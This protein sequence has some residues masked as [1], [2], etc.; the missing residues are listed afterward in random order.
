M[1]TPWLPSDAL[2]TAKAAGFF[3]APVPG[4]PGLR[5]VSLNTM[6]ML[7]GNPS[8]SNRTDDIAGQCAWFESVLATARSAGEHVLV[9]G[10]VPPTIEIAI[11]QWTPSQY[12]RFL[13][14]FEKYSDVIVG[15]LYGHEHTDSFS[16]VQ[17][18]A[19][20]RRSIGVAHVVPSLTPRSSTC[21]PESGDTDGK[22]PALRKYTVSAKGIVGYVQYFA[23][24]TEANE[25]HGLVWREAYRMPEEFADFGFR[26]FSTESFEALAGSIRSDKTAWCRYF[27]H[28]FAERTYSEC[29]G[30]CRRLQ[31][32][33]LNTTSLS[34]YFA[35]T[36]S[37][38]KHF[39]C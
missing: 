27:K 33:K 15:G 23:N 18:D 17:P 4:L 1:W 35:C 9:I 6:L 7:T 5:I 28:W 34:R 13:E 25:G 26:D 32:C 19:D 20:P 24:L 37:D 36:L 29:V 3:A 14:V 22:H 2:A 12:E 8:T 21:A 30:A 10:H 38:I 11:N 31:V 39:D 16:L